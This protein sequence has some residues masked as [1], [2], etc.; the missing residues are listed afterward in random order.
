MGKPH[1]YGQ[2]RWKKSGALFVG[3]FKQG[4]KHGTGKWLKNEIN[5]NSN[6]YAG[7]YLND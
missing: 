6:Q 1:G 2:Y 7:D 4:M 3:E 5:K